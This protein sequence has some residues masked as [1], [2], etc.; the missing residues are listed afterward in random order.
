MPQKFR[1]KKGKKFQ[2]KFCCIN[3]LAISSIFFQPF[4]LFQSF[5]VYFCQ[6]SLTSSHQFEEKLDLDSLCPQFMFS[7]FITLPQFTFKV[8]SIDVVCAFKV[9]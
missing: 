1:G 9:P 2:F 7:G 4:A 5:G 8:Y 3:L 6:C